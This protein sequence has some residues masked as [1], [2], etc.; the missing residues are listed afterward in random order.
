[1]K[2][3]AAILIIQMFLVSNAFAVSKPQNLQIDIIFV[4]ELDSLISKS[5]AFILDQKFQKYDKS[6]ADYSYADKHGMKFHKDM[7]S[8]N[9]RVA[10]PALRDQMQRTDKIKK[11]YEGQQTSS[12]MDNKFGIGLSIPL[13]SGYNANSGVTDNKE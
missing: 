13:E 1:M 8:N 9:H 10:N 2:I 11:V 4:P 7:G 3:R 6:R 5:A 12:I